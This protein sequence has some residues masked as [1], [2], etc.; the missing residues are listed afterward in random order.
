M[1]NKDPHRASF[2]S[3]VKVVKVQE[4]EAVN[5]NHAAIMATQKPD[6]WGWGYRRLYLLV[7]M[8]FLCSTMNGEQ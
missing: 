2:E 7:A 4:F 5:P 3:D 8:I 1:D 6:P